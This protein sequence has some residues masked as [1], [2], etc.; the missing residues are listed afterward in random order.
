MAIHVNGKAIQSSKVSEVTV[1]K[2]ISQD[3]ICKV[4]STLSYEGNYC[5]FGI[6]N[7][8]ILEYNGKYIYL[9]QDPKGNAYYKFDIGEKEYFTT[10]TTKLGNALSSHFKSIIEAN[11]NFNESLG[12]RIS[13]TKGMSKALSDSK[14]HDDYSAYNQNYTDIEVSD[15]HNN[16]TQSNSVEELFSELDTDKSTNQQVIQHQP[17]INPQYPPIPNPEQLHEQIISLSNNQLDYNK[18]INSLSIDQFPM[19]RGEEFGPDKK[20][21]F[22]LAKNGSI[23]RNTYI[24]TKHMTE[25]IFEYD[26]N[27]S[28]IMSIIP[29]MAKNDLTL[30]MN[31]F[32]WLANSFNSV[33]KLPFALV[34]HSD[35][36]TLMKLLYEE[37]LELLF[38]QPHCEKIDND[39]L[40]K[41]SLS[42]QIDK[43]VIINFHNVLTP[44]ILKAPAKELT[45]RLIYKDD[46]KLNTKVI[47]TVA[48]LLITSTSKY[49]PLIA[50]DVPCVVVEVESSL[51]AFC[52]DQNIKNDYYVVANLIEQDLVNFSSIVRSID[53]HML[54]NM[55]CS[56]RYDGSNTD[57][58]DGDTDLLKVFE[59]SFKNGDKVLW[60]I[61]ETKSPEL[62]RTLLDDYNENRVN[63]KN[64][65]E[66]FSLIFG[67]GI[68]KTNTVLIA[69]LRD[70]SSTDEPFDNDKISQSGKI[71]YY[72]LYS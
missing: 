28:F 58:M 47:P 42:N 40:D 65:L 29:Y 4:R 71:V 70:L 35:G 50:K 27:N 61:I 2:N 60:K 30:A 72:K 23:L 51:E 54:N 36:D 39:K 9:W 24:A 41:K 6:G 13:A 43:T 66:Y 63:R 10:A 26:V 22:F 8:L 20:L 15:S 21:A 7:V 38:N 64:L 52:K 53:M 14:K 57:I 69:A 25:P 34:L 46:Y 18:Q 5:F 3:F 12:K 67:K 11:N 17:V 19:V 68:Y 33:K 37:I 32:G 55:L 59:S 48:N 45:R 56:R 1:S 62:H 16:N 31:I 44:T 49:I